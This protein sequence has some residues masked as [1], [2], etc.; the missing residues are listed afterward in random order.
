MISDGTI[1]PE[2]VLRFGK[3]NKGRFGKDGRTIKIRKSDLDEW[4]ESQQSEGI[5]GGGE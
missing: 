4:I 5:P 1:P 2:I 3:I